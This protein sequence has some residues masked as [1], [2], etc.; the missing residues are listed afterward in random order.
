[1]GGRTIDAYVRRDWINHS[2]IKS[3]SDFPIVK[4]FEHGLDFMDRN[5]EEDNWYLQIETFDLHKAFHFADDIEK[6]IFLEEDA[7]SMLSKT[8]SFQEIPPITNFVV[9]YLSCN[10]LEEP[11]RYAF[12]AFFQEPTKNQLITL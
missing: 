9:N 6:Y 11:L 5:H 3:E 8:I 10:L 7:M 1:M 2:E 4:T 12:R